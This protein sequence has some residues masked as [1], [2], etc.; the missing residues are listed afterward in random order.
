MKLV[1]NIDIY[2]ASNMA[3]TAQMIFKKIHLNKQKRLNIDN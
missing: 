2:C 1:E 3:V